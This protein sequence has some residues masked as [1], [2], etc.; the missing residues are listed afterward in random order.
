MRRNTAIKLYCAQRHNIEELEQW[1]VH[2]NGTVV[3]FNARGLHIITPLKC[4]R[5][6]FR[7]YVL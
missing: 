3:N 1:I 5:H 6:P 2:C 4:Q 7:T